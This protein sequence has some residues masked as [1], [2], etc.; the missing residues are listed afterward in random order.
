MSAAAYRVDLDLF[1]GPIDLLLYLVR[2]SE[3]EASSLTLTRVVEQFR[4]M[5]E[6]LEL[7]GQQLDLDLAGD[8]VVAVATLLEI[9]GRQTLP[10]EVDEAAE[11]VEAVEQE[12]NA[13]L[14]ARLLQF[15]RFR[16][17]ATGLAEQAARQ[18]ERY[19]RMTVERP[20][21]GSD[22]AS[23]R[24]RGIEIWDLLSAFSRIAATQLDR[25]VETIRDEEVPVHV[26]V[27]Q[28]AE[29][30]RQQGEVR[31]HALFDGERSRSRVVGLFLAILELVRHHGYAAEQLGD[32]DI[33]ICP[34]A[35]A[36]SDENRGRDERGDDG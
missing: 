15:K 21:S 27:E 36:T 25:G 2:R 3:I 12:P 4:E 17:A 9:K 16:D 19:T 35:E 7:I 33:T 24:I 10:Q 26:Y 1:T 18:S 30:I 22:P 28:V 13:D 8:F 23:D 20:P 29:R 5:V 34:P 11:P 6:A 31:F 32:G 14:V